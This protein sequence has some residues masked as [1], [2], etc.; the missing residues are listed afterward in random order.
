MA[1]HG[2]QQISRL[3]STMSQQLQRIEAQHA[4]AVGRSND[5]IV[6]LLE[7]FSVFDRRI[8]VLVQ[9]VQQIIASQHINA[10][11]LPRENGTSGF[12]LSQDQW[13][14]RLTRLTQIGRD[15]Q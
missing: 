4:N 3:V 11:V 8:E 10:T 2:E 1:N 15:N 12:P 5:E 9:F 14:D 6:Q 7:R 13:I